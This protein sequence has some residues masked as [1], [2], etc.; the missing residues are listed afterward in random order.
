[1]LTAF[2]DEMMPRGPG[3]G[4]ASGGVRGSV[5]GPPRTT[6]RCVSVLRMAVLLS[7]WAMPAHCLSSIWRESLTGMTVAISALRHAVFPFAPPRLPGYHGA[8]LSV[9]STKFSHAHLGCTVSFLY[10]RGDGPFCVKVISIKPSR[11]LSTRSKRKGR[12]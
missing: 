12:L 10:F 11:L 2:T 7:M 5:I 9:Y 8:S 1:M 4:A 6:T 3:N